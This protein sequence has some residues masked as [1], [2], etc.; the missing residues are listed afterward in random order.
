MLNFSLLMYFQFVTHSISQSRVQPCLYFGL[1]L[2]NI[3][4]HRIFYK[5]Q[6]ICILNMLTF[7]EFVTHP[8]ISQGYCLVYFLDYVPGIFL[9][10]FK[11]QNI[12]MANISNLSFCLSDLSILR[13]DCPCFRSV[14]ILNVQQ[15]IWIQIQL[16]SLTHN[17]KTFDP[18]PD[19]QLCIKVH[20]FTFHFLI[21]D[22][23]IANVS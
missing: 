19:P 10:F 18:N 11:L 5:I 23:N 9:N 6:N 14:C 13:T 22:C 16:E 7:E 1:Y 4:F 17:E 12:C 2:R 8:V 21:A 15:K 3:A 20:T